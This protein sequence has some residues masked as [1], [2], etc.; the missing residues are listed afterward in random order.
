MI[1]D[2]DYDYEAMKNVREGLLLKKEIEQK[3]RSGRCNREARIRLER[4][5]QMLVD[6]FQGK[7]FLIHIIEEE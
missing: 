6:E 3:L 1:T 4:T 2:R 5:L 7:P